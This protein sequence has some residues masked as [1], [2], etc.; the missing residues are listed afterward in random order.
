MLFTGK[1]R[2]SKSPAGVPILFIH[3]PCGKGLRLSIDYGGLNLVTVFGD[4]LASARDRYFI[5]PEINLY[6]SI[7]I[8]LAAIQ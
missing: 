5:I 1:I 2:L 4:G 6:M 8:I 7:S 3:K